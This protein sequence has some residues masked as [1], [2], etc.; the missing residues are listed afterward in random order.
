MSFTLFAVPRAWEGK[1]GIEQE[2][3]VRSW[4]LLEP[5]PEVILFYDDPGTAEAAKE[6]GCVYAP[7]LGR[8]EHG[9]PYVHHVF[10]QAQEMAANDLMASI[11]CDVILMQDFADALLAVADKFPQFC[12]VGQRLDVELDWRLA[13]K[14]GWQMFLRAWAKSEGRYYTPAGTDYIGF[15]RGL[16]QDVPPFLYGR[17]SWDNWLMAHPQAQGVPLVDATQAVCAVHPEVPTGKVSEWVS[18][19]PHHGQEI[20]QNRRLLA[21]TYG[22]KAGRCGQAS[23]MVNRQGE[24]ILRGTGS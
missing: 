14:E 4:L 6:Y 12:M 24:V 22:A 21:H 2:N 20:A 15:R 9:T 17:S 23:W 18:R 1:Y 7:D 5:R 13:F 19:L 3:A 8:N 16:Y 10:H 11:T